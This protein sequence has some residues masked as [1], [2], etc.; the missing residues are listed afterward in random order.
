MN[1][2]VGAPIRKLHDLLRTKKTSAQELYAA[3]AAHI[4]AHD[5]GKIDAFLCMTESLAKE[6]AK[7]VDEM[8]ARGDELPLLAGIPVAVKDNMCLPGYPTTCASKILAGFVPPYSAFALEKLFAQG[9]VLVGKT[10]MDEFAMGSSTENSSVKRTKNPWNTAYVPGGSSGGSSA[11]VAAG[12]AV[13]SLGSDTGGSIRQPA[14]FCGVV[15]MKPTFGAVSRFGLVAYA[16]SLDQIGPFGRCV[17]DVA[18]MLEAIAGHDKRDSTSLPE[19]EGLFARR[20]GE[21]FHAVLSKAPEQLVKGKRI[22]IIKELLGEGIE[23]DV[24]EAIQSAAKALEAM[25]ASV[26][27]VSIPHSKYALPV[28]YILATAEA[29][30]NLARYDGVRYGHRSEAPDLMNMYLQSRNE[31]FGAEVKRRIMLGTYALSSGYYEA[32]YKKAQQ[33]RRLIK[34][35]FD[36]IF[37]S[38][39]CVICPTAPSEPFKFDEKTGHPLT[40]YLQ[41]IATIPANLAGLP[42]ISVPCGF[43]R[44]NL[45]IGLQILGK[46]LSDGTILEVAAAYERAT[47][48]GKKQAPTLVGA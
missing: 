2:L 7:R 44:N 38:V 26:V 8:I 45:P 22:G 16:S 30:A 36:A 14:S 1:E 24:R 47:E 19:S 6:Q 15:G 31:G 17:E 33:V 25:G 29:S 12:F 10:N 3:H 9:A 35:D 42:G 23:P 34:N 13:A 40:M 41:D 32:Y 48:F 39:D 18:I 43:G 27:E 5:P 37:E 21:Y 46:P 4:A 28:Y 20:D 11:A